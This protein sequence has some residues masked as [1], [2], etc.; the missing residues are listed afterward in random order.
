MNTEVELLG[1]RSV[2]AGWQ[3]AAGSKK[4]N[5]IIMRRDLI[6]CA[7]LIDEL[8][9]FTPEQNQNGSDWLC[10]GRLVYGAF[11]MDRNDVVFANIKDAK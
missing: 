2:A 9:I 6:S 11:R 4:V 7:S 5:F 3:P 8:K 10:E 1:D